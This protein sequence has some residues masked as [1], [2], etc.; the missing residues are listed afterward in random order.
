MGMGTGRRHT[1][2]RH[3]L[4]RVCGGGLCITIVIYLLFA[5]STVASSTSTNIKCNL[6]SYNPATTTELDLKKCGLTALPDTIST[7]GSLTKL[8]LSHN[9]NLDSLPSLPP[10]LTTLFAL[11][12]GFSTI[13]PAVAALPSLR[14]L[15]F[16]SCRLRDIGALPLPTSLQWL[17]L[18]DNKL[19]TLPASIGGLV[20]M[21][22]LMLAN[23]RLVAL[24]PEMAA[25]RELELLRLAN[26]KLPSIPPW[27]STL[28]K[29]TWLA[30]AG[31]PCVSPAPAR[32]ELPMVR[33]DELT[34][35]ARLGEG[36]SSI[37]HKGQ[38]HGHQVALKVYKAQLSSD[39]RNLDEVR[40][41]CA[42][43]HPHVLRW[44]GYLEEGSGGEEARATTGSTGGSWRLIGVLEW[45]AGF[46]SLGKPPSMESITR[47]T[48]PPNTQFSGSEVREIA[49]GIAS[50]LEHLHSRQIA[51]GD[52]YAHNILWRS[53]KNGG[54]AVAKLSD[55]G[56]A[57]YYG[58]VG[59]SA[60]GLRYER[61]EQRAFGLLLEELIERHDGSEPHAIVAVQAAA[62]AATG[63]EAQ[64]PGFAALTELLG[65]GREH[66]HKNDG[67]G[68]RSAS[69]GGGGG[70]GGGK[71][72]RR[73]FGR[74][75]AEG[76]PENGEEE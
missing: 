7:F 28:P 51:H 3:T 73:T 21:R 2:A 35:G 23:N 48:Y 5:N 19:H 47:D 76:H 61:M 8:D 11:G 16:K 39:G 45:A 69:E 29:L 15:S 4:L 10:T 17:I 74:A 40:A 46:G 13:P 20:R 6:D 1:P 62:A 59:T 38:Y 37:V 31:N 25:M 42:V 71:R 53:G 67:G 34:I 52:L 66:Q 36:T 75:T 32:A 43:D 65:A 41:S 70:G 33:Y 63:V 44:L 55:F 57:F 22:K 60:D 18:T 56:A 64:R 26:N 72:P 9:P 27:L 49:H 30:I 58:G 68:R 14:M 54:S 50:A 24:P 12:S